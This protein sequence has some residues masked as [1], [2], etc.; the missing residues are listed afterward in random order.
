[1]V[2]WQ[3][4]ITTGKALHHVLATFNVELRSCGQCYG[5]RPGCGTQFPG[6]CPCGLATARACD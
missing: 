4:N 6:L 3:C 5:V 2:S 1:M